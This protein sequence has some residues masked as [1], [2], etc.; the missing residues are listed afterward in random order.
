MIGSVEA[1]EPFPRLPLWGRFLGHRGHPR[2]TSPHLPGGAAALESQKTKPRGWPSSSS[3]SSSPNSRQ[4]E[5]RITGDIPHLVVASSSFDISSSL[6]GSHSQNVHFWKFPRR[7]KEATGDSIWSNKLD[8][9]KIFKSLKPYQNAQEVRNM[10]CLESPSSS[11]FVRTGR[12]VFMN[13]TSKQ[14]VVSIGRSENVPTTSQ[15][16]LQ[17]G[18]NLIVLFCST[19]HNG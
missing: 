6:P 5:S 12:S 16:N 9:V 2:H 1:P 7:T 4:T 14:W 3:S 10:R 19:P 8:S 18:R 13:I 11:T 15:L 17:L